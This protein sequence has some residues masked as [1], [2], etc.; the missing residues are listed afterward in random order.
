MSTPNYTCMTRLFHRTSLSKSCETIRIFHR[1]IQKSNNTTDVTF[2]KW[3]AG[4]YWW[5]NEQRMAIVLNDRWFA[6]ASILKTKRKATR[7]SDLWWKR[8]VLLFEW[9][10]LEKVFQVRFEPCCAGATPERMG[11]LKIR[12]G[13]LHLFRDCGWLR[14][15]E[16]YL[17]NLLSTRC[18]RRWCN[19]FC[20]SSSSRKMSEHTRNESS[21]GPA[22]FHGLCFWVLL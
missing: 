11:V 9:W 22:M 6:S 7:W 19:S 17:G 13:I 18:F 21:F 2:L 4:A 14:Y 20:V 5:A 12:S 10:F 3:P 15:V 1:L 8:R 16:F